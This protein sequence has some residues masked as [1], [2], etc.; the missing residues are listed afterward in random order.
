MMS[1]VISVDSN[2]AGGWKVIRQQA[3]R[4]VSNMDIHT[5]HGP[6]SHDL[7]IVDC[8]FSVF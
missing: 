7:S 6:T 8:F 4:E 1:T 3:E 5:I 2:R